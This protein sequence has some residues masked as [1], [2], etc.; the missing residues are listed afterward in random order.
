MFSTKLFLQHEVTNSETLNKTV[1]FF[2][3]QRDTLILLLNNVLPGTVV[4]KL[5]LNPS[6]EIFEFTENATVL[7]SDLASFTSLSAMVSPQEIVLMLNTLFEAFDNAA[8][9]R[10][11][12]KVRNVFL[13][14]SSPALTL[15]AF[16][17]S[18]HIADYYR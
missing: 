17:E 11:A 2:K 6:L 12:E 10:G 16:H 4:D 15:T 3:E 9:F 1:L 18:L 13:H 8:L 14:F 5:L 7:S